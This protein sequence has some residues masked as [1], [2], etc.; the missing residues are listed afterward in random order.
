MELSRFLPKHD[1]CTLQYI[2]RVGVIAQRRQDKRL[3][4]NLVICEQSYEFGRIVGHYAVLRAMNAL[5]NS[6]PVIRLTASRLYSTAG[7]DG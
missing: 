2:Q 5:R 1:V 3:Q 4:I 6:A 7:S